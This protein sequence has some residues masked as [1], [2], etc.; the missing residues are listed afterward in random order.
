MPARVTLTFEGTSKHY[1]VND[2]NAD[3]AVGTAIRAA[4]DAG[5]LEQ[6]GP[7]VESSVEWLLDC[8]A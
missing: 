5:D 2:Y 1:D 3:W 6:H 8:Q 4:E 7:V